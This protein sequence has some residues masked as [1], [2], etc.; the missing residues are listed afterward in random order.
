MTGVLA[1][2]PRPSRDW[3]WTFA[4]LAALAY[5]ALTGILCRALLA[6]P[7]A[8]IPSDRGD[9]ILNTW[10]LWWGTQVTPFTTAW[11]NAPAFAPLTGTL[12][13]SEHLA[14][15]LPLTLPAAA[16]GLSPVLIYNLIFV[17][18]FALSALAT[19]AL[20]CELTSRRDVAFFAGIVYG[21]APYRIAQLPHL[22]VLVS[23]GIPV[24]FLALH[25]YLR[26]RRPRWLVLLGIAWIFQAL[27][28]GYFLFFIPVFVGLWLLWFAPR[29]GR[30]GVLG[31]TVTAIVVAALLA[32]TLIRYRTIHQTLDLERQKHEAENY[33]ADVTGIIDGAGAL[34]HWHRRSPWRRGEGEM[35]PGRAAPL[36]AALGVVLGAWG[37]TRST[38]Y[39]EQKRWRIPAACVLATVALGSGYD[40]YR[41]AD[42]K[43]TWL[44][45]RFPDRPFAQALMAL[46][47][48]GLTSRALRS[49]WRDGSTLG[50]YALSGVLAWIFTCG[51]RIHAFGAL[52]WRD[53]PYAWLMR[54]PG[55]TALRVPTRFAMIAML[56]L[57]VVAALGLARLTTRRR[58]LSM[59]LVAAASAGAYADGWVSKLPLALAYPAD[60]LAQVLPA[61]CDVLEL[62]I[63]GPYDDL[64]VMYRGMSHQRRLVNGYSGHIPRH[65]RSL[66]WALGY[67]E[68]Q[69]LDE[70][71]RERGLCVVV[72]EDSRRAARADSWTGF[73]TAH[74][75]AVLIE[76]R[77][78]RT[79]FHVP[80][81]TAP[82]AAPTQTL[83]PGSITA[84]IAAMELGNLL[85]GDPRTR[86]LACPQG[87]RE[88]LRIDV[89][90]TRP[91]AA[92]TLGL[93]EHINDFPRELTVE[94]EN[95]GVTTMIMK[96]PTA[97]LAFAGAVTDARRVPIRIPLR[98][99]RASKII[100]RQSGVATEACWTVTDLTVEGT[101]P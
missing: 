88:E 54:L 53:A 71:A 33:S 61:G 92:V 59:L 14:G 56:C 37:R 10:I 70:L 49:A 51:P 95:D 55:F 29:L 20:V 42:G 77:P 4:L 72:N 11:W 86:W 22:Q 66:L 98:G 81:V 7:E 78:G 16:L 31:V 9:P 19:Y 85:D 17:L 82:P 27:A 24:V 12:A 18:S 32:P 87:G 90:P 100:L 23:W 25:R 64:A 94:L 21:F 28:N 13:L 38:K 57:A 35:F 50:F 89:D 40:I 39:V 41:V 3:T 60:D 43:L 69:V 99:R 30:S 47:L 63:G 52:V 84:S 46:V 96:G 75:R 26:D 6:A 2:E 76:D 74:P 48:V 93:G 45:V 36:L 79:I 91:L 15:L 101:K 1:G 80:S 5:A 8:L 44:P 58:L 97:T 83:Q 68:P 73:I 34:A 67:R 65:Y 62:P